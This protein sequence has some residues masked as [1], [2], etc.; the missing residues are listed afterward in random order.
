M[1]KTPIDLDHSDVIR[2]VEL[3]VDR[4]YYTT[5][6]APLPRGAIGEQGVWTTAEK[7]LL[8]IILLAI[9][10]WL[11]QSQLEQLLPKGSVTWVSCRRLLWK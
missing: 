5:L 11:A 2:Q 7:R 9:G 1:V 6:V 4:G 8:P 10:L 3:A